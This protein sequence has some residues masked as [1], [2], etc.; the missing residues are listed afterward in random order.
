M[1]L[2][3]ATPSG[4]SWSYDGPTPSARGFWSART[5]APTAPFWFAM[6]AAS[7]L[8]TNLGDFWA[9]ALALGLWSAFATMMAVCLVAIACDLRFGR[10]TEIF[11][12]AAIVLLRAAATN[13][14][15]FLT[16]EHGVDMLFVT[17]AFGAATVALALVAPR[18]AD[19]S[20]SPAIDPLYWAI[21]LLAGIFG[22]VGG[23]FVSA[24]IGVFG[25][26]VLLILAL[27]GAI[28]ARR[29]FLANSL[30][31]YWLVIMAER[32]AGTPI[33][34]A[35]QGADGLG[36]GLPVSMACMFAILLAGLSI[37]AFAPGAWAGPTRRD[38]K[39]GVR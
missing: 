37:R 38:G 17:A 5:L 15:D 24:T 30:A 6:L 1:N 34:D 29:A 33:G 10:Q 9:D 20:D 3:P 39:P 4:S 36:F 32:A 8:G 31:A 13:I 35:A 12:W 28:W 16:H 21:M 18:N 23:D 2:P 19:R 14:A 22:T 26:A 7:A 25:A 11:Y 27:M